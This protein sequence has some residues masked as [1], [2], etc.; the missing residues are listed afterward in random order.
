MVEGSP[1]IPLSRAAEAALVNARRH[2]SENIHK[3]A[4][5][6]AALQRAVGPGLTKRQ[7]LMRQRWAERGLMSDCAL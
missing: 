3:I 1:T 4:V 5:G 7:A 2:N 6:G